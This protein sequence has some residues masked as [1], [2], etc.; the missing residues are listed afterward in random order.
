LQIDASAIDV[1]WVLTCTI[2]VFVM[3]AGFCCLECGLVRAKNSINVAIK[4][5]IDF[6]IAAGAFWAVG[7]A[8]MFGQTH[9][10][11]VGTTGFLFGGQ[12]AAWLTA[13][14]FFQLVFCGT[15]TTIVSGAVAERMRFSA[16]MA[17][18]L[19][20]S[21]LIYPLIGHWA[22]GGADLGSRTGWLN[23]RGFIDFAGSTVV[24]S[25]GGW[26]S[27]ASVLVLGPRTGRFDD[28]TKPIHGHN[29]PMST[30]GVLLLWL[31]WFGFNGGSE[32]RFSDRVP[33]I[34]V[35]TCLGG[36]F[37]ANTAL[38]ISWAWER[39][40]NV[41]HVMNGALAG[42]VAVT[43]SCHL[44]T[45]L[46]ASIIGAGGGIVY[47]LGD[48][49]L[50]RLRIDDAVGAVPV[51]AFGGVWGTLAVAL[52]C[53]PAR[54]GTGLTRW[55]QLLIQAQGVGACFAWA[56]GG[57]FLI[58]Q[59][60]N[61]VLP[62]RVSVHG[63]RVGLNIAEH[64]SSTELIDLLAE[65]ELH[66]RTG[67]FS[68]PVPVDPHT[69]VAS[70]AAQYNRVLREVNLTTKKLSHAVI[71]AEQSR[72]K[73]QQ[74][75][76]ELE[77]FN[78]LAVGRELRMVELKRQINDLSRELGLPPRYDLTFEQAEKQ[79]RSNDASVQG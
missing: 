51:H 40:P 4:N 17:V 7:Y 24:H 26:V 28:Q 23:G 69:E 66:R 12:T 79:S 53:D 55:E 25:T 20:V 59:L 63:E 41:E 73:L 37:G 19:I 49:L 1:L 78:Q 36:A 14:F 43:A 2:L 5:L 42:L 31:G 10:G 18:S 32:L 33:N 77:E 38:L 16:Y 64:G 65:M 47:L 71:D 11:W 8:L 34:L 13:F 70:V 15:A 46:R 35:H 45:P 67:D 21:A 44:V 39:R 60:L 56:F 22:W 54:W 30:L 57:G 75:I 50:R 74:T 62:L 6:C 52:C 27:L 72:D 9:G 48:A 58:L 76:Q 61:Q 29:L 68:Q 3:Q